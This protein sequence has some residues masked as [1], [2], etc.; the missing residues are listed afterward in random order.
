MLKNFKLQTAEHD[1]VKLNDEIVEFVKSSGVESGTCTI[2][3]P[4]T[5]AG[6]TITSFWDPRGLEDLQDE[7]RRIVPTRIDFKHQHDTPQDAA[8]HIKSSLIG[9]SMSLII[10]NGE[11]LLGH[12]QGIYFLEFD[13]PRNREFYVKVQSDK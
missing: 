8:G 6:L 13:G 9:V 3:T 5:T 2:Y 1:V 10:E 7:I 4:H 12:S 11:L